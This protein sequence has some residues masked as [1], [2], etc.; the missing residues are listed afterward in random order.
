MEQLFHSRKA[1]VQRKVKVEGDGVTKGH[2]GKSSSSAGRTPASVL[3]DYLS[4][5]ETETASHS[6]VLLLDDFQWADPDSIQALV[7]LS[8]NIKH[9]PVLM[10]VA[11]REDEIQDPSLQEILRILR[12]E[13]HAVDVPLAGLKEK[14]TLKL[15]ENIVQASLDSS[16]A[17]ATVNFLLER[18]GGNPYF[19]LEMVRH[20]QETGLMRTD[21]QQ[22]VL[23]LPLAQTSESVELTVPD[24][25]SKLL[26]KKLETLSKDERSILEGAAI[27]G[28]EFEVTPLEQLFR[29]HSENVANSLRKLASKKG[30]IV[31]KGEDGTR[32]TFAHALL[33][34]TVKNC[35]PEDQ[36][37]QMAGQL[38]AWWEERLP[39]DIER[40]ATLYELAGLN[41]KALTCVDKV[42]EV[43]LQTHAH[44]RISR[45]FDK[46][47]DLMEREGTPVVGMVEWGLS[48]V[49][50]LRG[51]GGDITW[52]EPMCRRLFVMNPPEPI[53]WELIIRLASAM[54]GGR[55]KGV[56]ELLG[57]VY[58][59]T[60]QRPELASPA[61]LGRLA[62]VD[63]RLLYSE[64]KWSDSAKR[65]R[66]A[67][68]KLPEEERFFRGDAY[69]GLGWIDMDLNHYG[70][71]TENLEKGLTVAKA[72][73]LWGLVVHLLNL[74][75]SIAS[76]MGDLKMAEDCYSDAVA[77]TRNIGQV[78]S[79]PIFL[80]N[81]S[82][83][84]KEL[85]DLEGAEMAAREAMRVAEAFDQKWAQG[86]A[87]LALGEVMLLEKTSSEAMECIKRARGI[88]EETGNMDLNVQ[89]D[90]DMA[91][92]T[93]SMGDPAGAL[94]ALKD[95]EEKGSLRQEQVARLH[96]LLA[97]FATE[98]GSKEE[99]RTEVE[100]ALDESR[101]RSLRFWEGQALIAF[102][103]WEKRFGAPEDAVRLKEQ[104]E[105]H[106]K[107][108]GVT[109]LAPF[110]GEL[111]EPEE[112]GELARKKGKRS[113]GLN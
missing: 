8:R 93:G 73:K 103:E 85:G 89:A 38:A 48:V 83:A 54:V 9:L 46:G 14:E 74:K 106:L 35:T 15:V 75:G 62:A 40:M 41:G 1:E 43:S 58:E 92:L 108:C 105:K 99:A 31:Q 23:D 86:V 72:G 2:E 18:T 67:L 12:R 76:S 61:L 78:L 32:Y 56:K 110:M 7:F 97:R 87:S 28:H 49:D 90:L 102:S 111:T 94:A 3:L 5:I 79:L 27:L 50:R 57:M 34:E 64:G 81:L 65:A 113:H 52:I 91:E 80:Y 36:R 17:A 37:K 10:L 60:R 29:S 100:R 16:K 101:R 44:E 104:A 77:T 96:V 6:C 11:L 98:T 69:T 39:A 26:T 68:A 95:L 59:G 47:L 66:D 51:D 25:V 55:I 45:Y 19:I 24:S 109:N 21:G 30:L 42:I 112:E 20:L 4:R 84:K 22:A 33:W 82:G 71:A 107:D 53:S 13:G 88:S 63:S 70:E